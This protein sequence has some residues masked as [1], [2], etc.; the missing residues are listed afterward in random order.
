[1]RIQQTR[2]LHCGSAPFSPLHSQRAH[3]RKQRRV[4]AQAHVTDLALDMLFAR[5]PFPLNAP[6]PHL[7]LIHI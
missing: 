3:Q 4:A 6:E 2:R 7:S 1:M 5:S